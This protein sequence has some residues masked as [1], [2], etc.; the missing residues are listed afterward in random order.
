MNAHR[1]NAQSFIEKEELK[2]AGMLFQLSFLIIVEITR[3]RLRGV[4]YF[5]D[6]FFAKRISSVPPVFNARL[7]SSCRHTTQSA[8]SVSSII[9]GIPH[10]TSWI[11]G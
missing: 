11:A 1:I 7:V 3:E 2:Y 10:C 6:I 8:A 9:A 5:H 4:D